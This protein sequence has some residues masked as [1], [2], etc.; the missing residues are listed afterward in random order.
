MDT[1]SWTRRQGNTAR[2][3][4]GAQT[5]RTYIVV[6]LYMVL[7]APCLLVQ[8]AIVKVADEAAGCHL[9]LF[10]LCLPSQVPEGVDDDTKNHCMSSTHNRTV[11]HTDTNP[12]QCTRV[13]GADMHSVQKYAPPFSKITTTP[14]KKVRS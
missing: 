10:F 1:T 9:I 11:Q 8:Q 13:P 4:E 3:G 6:L 2:E 14:A 7:K 12:Y 5:I